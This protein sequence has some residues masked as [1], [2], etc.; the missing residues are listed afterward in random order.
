MLSATE[1]QEYKYLVGAA[2]NFFPVPILYDHTTLRMS[3]KQHQNVGWP[4]QRWEGVEAD[5]SF[6]A[7]L[8]LFDP[9]TRILILAVNLAE[10]RPKPV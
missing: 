4:R 5:K 2:E 6:L 10:Y 8:L 9:L 3:F 7:I 1:S